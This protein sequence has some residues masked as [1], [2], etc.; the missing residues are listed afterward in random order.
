V[1]TFPT[2]EKSVVVLHAAELCNISSVKTFYLTPEE[3]SDLAVVKSNFKLFEFWNPIEKKRI[4]RVVG[5][6]YVFSILR[7][8]YKGLVYVYIR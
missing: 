3:A 8:V 7:R 5:F 6:I 1:G 2:I 4:P